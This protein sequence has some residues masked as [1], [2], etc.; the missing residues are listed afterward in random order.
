MT[1]ERGCARPLSAFPVTDTSNPEEVRASFERVYGRPVIEFVGR[2]RRL[3]VIINHCRLNH[4]EINYAV[5][6]AVVRLRFPES[7]FVS[8]I[9]PIAGCGDAAVEGAQLNIDCRRSVLVSANTPLTITTGVEYERLIL[10]I[11][12][13]P[14]LS[15]LMALTGRTV[16]SPL[17][18]H[19]VQSIAAGAGRLLRDQLSFLVGKLNE[20]PHLPDPLI[21][22]FEQ[23]LMVMFLYANRHNY[24]EWLEPDSIEASP[25]EVRRAEEFIE[26]RAQ[27][28][29]TL[30]EL[31]AASGVSVLCLVRSFK[32]HRGY[33]PLQFLR[34]IRARPIKPADRQQE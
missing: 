11:R 2:E 24:S 4:L 21:T 31:A 23:A 17:R 14:L 27:N 9:F 25:V 10:C 6:G 32:K 16:T 5:Y 12:W 20:Q 33:S 7:C 34:E 29:I 1:V 28:A 8:Q 19:P 22:E 30:D 18:L 15:T 13:R 26:A 3:N